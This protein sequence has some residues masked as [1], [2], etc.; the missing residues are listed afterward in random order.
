[1]ISCDSAAMMNGSNIR[2]FWMKSYKRWEP[3][4]LERE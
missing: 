2:I 4:G 1:M 3:I